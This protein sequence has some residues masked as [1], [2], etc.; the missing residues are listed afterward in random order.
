MRRNQRFC[1]E[2]LR[3]ARLRAGL[4]RGEVAQRVGVSEATVKGWENG[5]RAPKASTHAALAKALGVAFETLEKPGPADAE[6]LRRLRESLGLTQA[7]AA[8]RMG[9]HASALKRVEAGAELPP[10]PK[11]MAR[12][13]GLTAADLAAVVRRTGG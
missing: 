5:T 7:E 12:V 9:I 3:A 6:D 4:R 13:Y 11:A 1:A 10:D 2:A 8:R